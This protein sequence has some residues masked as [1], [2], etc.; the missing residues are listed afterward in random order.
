MCIALSSYLFWGDITSRDE[1]CFRGKLTK[2]NLIDVFFNMI[3]RNMYVWCM[4]L[5]LF[6][7]LSYE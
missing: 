6:N 3:I 7:T 1:I 2:I 5:S 4:K